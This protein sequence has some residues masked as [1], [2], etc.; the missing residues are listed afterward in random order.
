MP[1]CK[2]CLDYQEDC[3]ICKSYD[4]WI[5]VKVAVPSITHG[6]VVWIDDKQTGESY[7]DLATY[8]ADTNLWHQ[9]IMCFED[10]KESFMD[11]PCNVTHW[12]RTKPPTTE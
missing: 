7:L 11:Q 8:F 2:L 6:F 10:G 12:R 4:K 9:C 1:H 3:E 5:N